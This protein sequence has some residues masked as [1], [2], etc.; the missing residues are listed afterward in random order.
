MKNHNEMINMKKNILLFLM[1]LLFFMA[2]DA[3]AQEW[4]SEGSCCYE[5]S[6]CVDKTNFYA[7]ILVGAN[8]L[9]NTAIEGNKSQNQPGYIMAVSL[10]FFWRFDLLWK[11]K[12]FF[13]KQ[14][15][16]NTPFLG[17]F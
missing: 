10:V 4:Y 15:K 11:R 17:K 8:F 7:K 1:S 2:A 9:Q 5:D 3:Q 16:K 12:F 13:S 6:C 14:R